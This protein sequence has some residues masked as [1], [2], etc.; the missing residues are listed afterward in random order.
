MLFNPNGA[1]RTGALLYGSP[2]GVLGYGGGISANVNPVSILSCDASVNKDGHGF[3][4]K[5]A[6]GIVAGN[7]EMNYGYGIRNDTTEISGISPGNTMG[8]GY[9]FTPKFRIQAQY[10]QIVLYYLGATVGF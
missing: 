1:V 7:Y 4:Y 10:N 3:T 2:D 9:R 8:I 6:V 5:P